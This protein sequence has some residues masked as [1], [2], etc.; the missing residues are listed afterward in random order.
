MLWLI[1][2]G[3][4]VGTFALV[5]RKA[6]AAIP[7][8]SGD[9]TDIDRGDRPEVNDIP[10]GTVDVRAL[11]RAA[12]APG[13]WP[14][15]FAMT[16]YG[17]S[18]AHALVGLGVTEGAPPFVH[19][20]KSTQEAKAAALVFKKNPWLAPCWSPAVYSFGSGGLFAMLPAAALAAFKTDP[21]MQCVHPWSIFDPS[22]SMIYAA[23]FARRLQ[24]WSNWDGTVLSLRTGWGNPSAMGRTTAKGLA[25]FGAHCEAVGLPASFLD[26]KLPRWKPAPAGELWRT[27]G[28]DDGWL[29]DQKAS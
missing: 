19:M 4:L 29:P 8:D 11:A 3:L 5:S 21:A 16:A 17:E 15:F 13:P 28:V 23:W 24:G 7:N 22:A 26:T 25:K 6:R 14:D 2:A 10:S 27:M 1:P 20:N 12:G 9:V 18:K